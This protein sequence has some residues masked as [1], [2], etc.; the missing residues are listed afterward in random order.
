MSTYLKGERDSS[1]GAG[2]FATPRLTRAH[3]DGKSVRKHWTDDTS[4]ETDLRNAHRTPRPQQRDTRS[5]RAHARRPQGGSHVRPQIKY[6][7]A[8]TETTSSIPSHHGGARPESA[9]TKETGNFANMWRLNDVLLNNQ[10]VN[11]EI[12]REINSTL[13]QKKMEIQH[14]KAYLV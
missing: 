2:D 10:C 13:R 14:T 5:L 11:K 1:S 4:E 8:E 7:A 3:P 6:Q 9:C 12:K